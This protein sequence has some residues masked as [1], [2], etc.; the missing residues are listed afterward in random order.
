[1]SFAPY[2]LLSTIARLSVEFGRP[3]YVKGG[4]GNTSAKNGET[5]WIKPSGRALC[6]MTDANF[7]AINR[8]KLAAVYAFQP[9][10]DPAQRESAVKD[11]MLAARETGQ[12]GRPSVETPLHDLLAATFVVHTHAVAVNGM[13]C[14]KG[15][16]EA[17]ARLFPNSLWVPYIDPGYTLSMEVRRS[18][19][20][21]RKENGRDPAVIF[22]ENHG[23]FV[24]AGEEHLVRELYA[25]VLDTLAEEY[26]KRNIPFQLKHGAPT[27]D[28]EAGEIA[29]LIRSL[30]GTDGAF[31]VASAPFALAEGPLS[32]DHMVYSK[33]YPYLGELTPE[34]I[35][36][37]REER[38]YS[39]RVISTKVGV[40]GV[41][42]SVK[43]AQLALDLAR[44]GAQ[45]LQLTEAFG[46]VQWMSEPA[47]KFIES[48]EVESYREQQA[49]KG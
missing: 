23:I 18:L 25:H 40:F 16:R 6:E 29:G 14:A 4:G 34:G 10:A 49:M 5:L 27:L 7:V 1:M 36:E 47:R 11:L 24:G 12:D 38:G 26:R 45:V 22:L 48:W 37:F 9:P 42:R 41:G 19:Q 46:G 13:T 2:E 32:P 17:A 44:D 39:P 35:A 30:L 43:A 3:D 31:T 21:Y 8:A 15:G 28:E 33:A 20:D